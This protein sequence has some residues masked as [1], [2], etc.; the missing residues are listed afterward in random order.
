MVSS[1]GINTSESDEDDERVLITP[2][3]DEEGICPFLF[4]S[5]PGF[6]ATAIIL[7]GIVAPNTAAGVMNWRIEN[8]VGTKSSCVRA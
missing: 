1:V 5:R 3:E 2:I 4:D 6:G 8:Q 7:E